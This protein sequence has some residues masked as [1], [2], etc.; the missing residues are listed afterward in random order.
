MN[1]LKKL[2][3]WTLIKAQ[4]P[5][6][7]WFLSFISFIESSFFPIPPDIILIPMI[8]AKRTNA[9]FYAFICTAS[10]V[11]GGIFGYLIGFYLFSSLGAIILNYYGLDSQ[12]TVFENYYLKYGVWI[13]LGAGFTP[14]PFKFITIASGVFGVNILLFIFVTII[15]RGL[16]FYLIALLLK[17]FGE[18]IE[19]LINKYFN[20]LTSLFFILLVG[21]IVLLKIL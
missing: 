1:Y 20:I 4:H 13:I 12:F 6:A 2:Y 7:S 21:S 19:K 11:L 17:I 8:I 14:F 5:N 15:A 9:F 16:R 10:S 18:I 3:D